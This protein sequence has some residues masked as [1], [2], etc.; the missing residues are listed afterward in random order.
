MSIIY[1]LDD[2]KL[3]TSF[4]KDPECILHTSYKLDRARGIQK[5]A[6]VDKWVPQKPSLG[7]G[8]FGTVRL[9]KCF[10]AGDGTKPSHRA[11]KQLNKMHMSRMKI[12]YKKELIA[13][14][15]FSRSK[16]SRYQVFVEFLGWFEDEDY[17]FLAMEYFPLGSLDR[18]MTDEIKER[19]AKIISLQLL[20]GLAVMHEEGFTH[21]DLKP[22]NIFVVQKQPVWWVK[23]GDFGI[24]KR[25][26]NNDTALHTATG[27]PPYLAPEVSHYV[28]TGNDES[29]TY[30]KAVDVWSF[31]CV[32]YQQIMALQVPFPNYPRSL[33]SFCR[34]GSFPIQPLSKRKSPE[35]IDFI[36]SVLIPLPILRPRAQDLLQSE[37]L[38]IEDILPEIALDTTN[39]ITGHAPDELTAR[40][41]AT[42]L[43]GVVLSSPNPTAKK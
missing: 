43:D 13:L 42:K 34:G 2:Y 41:L 20:E 30:T 16:F 8:T 6:I 19:D 7:A 24:T 17:I 15:K 29:E 4:Q 35:G 40:D 31:A 1:D 9:E 5:V 10:S 12:D 18:F 22:H 23:I 11:A 14:T 25:V 3:E 26:S 39:Q 36:K 27:T 28:E 32:V 33:L 21:R 37:W 38:Q